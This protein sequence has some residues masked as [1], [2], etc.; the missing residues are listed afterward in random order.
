MPDTTPEPASAETPDTGGR[1]ITHAAKR[2]PKSYP[3]R[4]Q[5]KMLWMAI[6]G[7][8][9]LTLGALV[10]FLIVL[11]G[12]VLGYLQAFI[13]P[14]AVAAVLTYLLA[15]L[16]DKLRERGL[17]HK[18]ASLIV[19]LAFLVGAG[20]LIAAIA[21]PLV[22]QFRQLAQRS[23]AIYHDFENLLGKNLSPE[24]IDTLVKQWE[25]HP[26]GGPIIK[27][28]PFSTEA[29]KAAEKERQDKLN[30]EHPRSPLFADPPPQPETPQPTPPNGQAPNGP[31]AEP[32]AA[33]P[34]LPGLPG[35]TQEADP[36]AATA[37]SEE[38]ALPPPWDVKQI[39]A[40]LAVQ[41]PRWAERTWNSIG[42]SIGGVLG[43]L[44]FVLNFL[45]VPI[46]L[47]FFLRETHSIQ[48]NWSDYLPLRASRFKD[49]I[50]SLL[51]EIN[52]Y[53]IAFFRGQMLVSLI[54]GFFTAVI[55]SIIGL[56]FGL[57]IGV[58]VGIL[59]IIPYIGLMVCLIPAVIIAIV[60][61]AQGGWEM[62][63]H[64]PWWVLP[65]IVIATFVIVNNLDGMLIAPKIVGDS[66]GLHPLVII[67]S[68]IFWSLLLGGLLGALLAVPLTATIQVLFRRYIWERQM[69]GG[70][71]PAPN[72]PS[73]TALIPAPP[74]SIIPAE[75]KKAP[76]PAPTQ[77]PPKPTPKR[78][79][80]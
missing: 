31:Q 54:D 65:A 26:V 48:A 33:P 50:V 75:E 17:S 80:R 79:R 61:S 29:R 15:P 10:I 18:R 78:R 63:P 56:K 21:V 74:T 5:L 35:L 25:K 11:T 49:E 71:G 3:T 45:L 22:S 20:T 16:V 37:G 32:D 27:F 64:A 12:R 73:S 58:L 6:T 2:T 8:S 23:P 52:G 67:A 34:G 76:A 42:R 14:V 44:G 57:L 38:E 39:R 28:T 59:G 46:Y 36:A 70:G 62:A 51:Q 43:G 30:G 72:A 69:E 68:V 55:L 53:L 19:F 4:W 1:E 40:W 60:Q 13:L 66:V 47:F 24:G 41:I 9:L 7:V 77:N